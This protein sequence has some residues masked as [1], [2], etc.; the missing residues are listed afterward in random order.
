MNHGSISRNTAAGRLYAVLAATP[1]VWRDAW[2][3]QQEA[4]VLALSTRISE[5]RHQLPVRE[6]VEHAEEIRGGDRRQYYRLVV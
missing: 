6:R 2:E 5:I 4:R 3:L 1:N